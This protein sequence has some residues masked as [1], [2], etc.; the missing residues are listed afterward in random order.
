M[1]ITKM[2]AF[3]LFTA[4]LGGPSE[5]WQYNLNSGKFLNL[6]F[7]LSSSADSN[8]YLIKLLG[9]INEFV[10]VKHLKLCVVLIHQ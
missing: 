3:S 2:G 5:I 6:C 9:G 10:F 7:F 4:V 8:A 1:R